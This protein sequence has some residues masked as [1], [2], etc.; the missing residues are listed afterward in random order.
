MK[1]EKISHIIDSLLNGQ[2]KQAK[3]Q[4]QYKNDN[5]QPAPHHSPLLKYLHIW[6]K[7]NN[8]TNYTIYGSIFI[9]IKATFSIIGAGGK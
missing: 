5:N 6:V 2:L 3:E 1:H 4:T 7:T 8:T 9:V